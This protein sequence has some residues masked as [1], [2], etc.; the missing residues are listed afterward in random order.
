[1]LKILEDVLL[2][3]VKAKGSVKRLGVGINVGVSFSRAFSRW[4]LEVTLELC[5]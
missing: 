2:R 5:S 3:A 4:T 1:M